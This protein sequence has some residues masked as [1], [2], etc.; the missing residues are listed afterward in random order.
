MKKFFGIIILVV[1]AAAVIIATNTD[2]SNFKRD[3]ASN[4]QWVDINLVYGGEKADFLNNLAVQKQL[5]KAKIRLQI[6]KAGSI[7]MVSSL[8]TTGKDCLW[9]SN[10]IS[11]EIAKNKGKHIIASNNIF[12]SPLV[13][14]A[15]KPVTRALIKAGIAKRE[16]K[17]TTVDTAKLIQFA[18]NKARWKEDLHLNI[19]GA[20]KLF[21]TDPRKSNSGNMWAGLLANMLN[22]GQVTTVDDLPVV[23]P[24][25]QNYFRTMGYMEQSSGDIF[26]NFLKQ[27]VGARPIIVAYENQLIEFL[28]K[29]Q[30]Y[31]NLIEKKI[32]ILYPTPTVFAS[33]PLISLTNQCQ[34]LDQALQMPKLQ[35]L[36]WQQH[37]FRSGLIGVDNDPNDLNLKNIPD[38]VTQV[39]PMPNAKVMQRIISALQ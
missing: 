11:V 31:Q 19:Y 12:N 39:M 10:Q 7:E 13:F 3:P 27:G 22:H 26:G 34:R 38:T 1:V 28:L 33:H 2:W 9:P 20:V 17:I 18:Q 14:Y 15:W 25:I 29:H 30:E 6:S 4:Q 16:G 8:P 32:D 23:L 21:S 5:K 35:Q 24:E 37:G 36:A